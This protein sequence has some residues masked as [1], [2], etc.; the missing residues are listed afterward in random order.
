LQE[1]FVSFAYSDF[2]SSQLVG[3]GVALRKASMAALGSCPFQ[4]KSF[5]LNF[6]GGE[7]R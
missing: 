5:A 6:D 1:Q 2:A 7:E 3:D 4:F